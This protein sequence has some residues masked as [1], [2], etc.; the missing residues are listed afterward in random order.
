M[1]A[2]LDG[3]RH[4]FGASGGRGRAAVGSRRCVD[5]VVFQVF[6]GIA[7]EFAVVRFV[8]VVAE[9]VAMDTQP[10]ESE[11]NS[12]DDDA[13]AKKPT[14]GAKGRFPIC[15]VLLFRCSL[16]VCCC[17]PGKNTSAKAASSSHKTKKA[18]VKKKSGK[19]SATSKGKSSKA[20]SGG[21]IKT[22]SKGK[23][24]GKDRV[25]KVKMSDEQTLY[26]I[27]LKGSGAFC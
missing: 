9:S 24:K 26:F 18:T 7:H 16:A 5:F 15:C 27:E 10:D 2:G 22:K 1:N 11:W 12:Q 4:R 3:K 25:E 23:A 20:K 14:K 19:G 21:K 8:C 17:V 6:N 13:V